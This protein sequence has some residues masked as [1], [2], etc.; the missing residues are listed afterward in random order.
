M[1]TGTGDAGPDS[2]TDVGAHLMGFLCG[3]TGGMLL[4]LVRNELA[5]RRWQ[6]IAAVLT[7]LLLVVAWLTAFLA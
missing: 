7:V 1:F 5:E 4:A 2:R 3:L 6:V